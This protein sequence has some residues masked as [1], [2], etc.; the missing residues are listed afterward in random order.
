MMKKIA[1]GFALAGLLGLSAAAGA[2]DID[3]DLTYTTLGVTTN[4]VLLTAA[5]PDLQDNGYTVLG[6]SGTRGNV[7]ITGLLAADGYGRNDNQ[8]YPGSIVPLTD[9][10]ISFTA[11]GVSYNVYNA[12]PAPPS[13]P[14]IAECNSVA[15]Q[16]CTY[17]GDGTPVTSFA[18][19]SA[20]PATVPEPAALALLGLGLAGL[21]ARRRRTA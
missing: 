15:N 20:G 16:T 7:A 4:A 11:G 17:I 13:S 10:G 8:L 1:L 12:T 3:W 5:T 9:D 6:I 18:L 2:Q 14:V 19:T 21:A